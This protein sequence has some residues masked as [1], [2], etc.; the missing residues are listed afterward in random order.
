LNRLVYQ[1]LIEEKITTSR[2][3]AVL[4]EPVYLVKEELGRWLSEEIG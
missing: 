2:A 4:G 1:S 3:A